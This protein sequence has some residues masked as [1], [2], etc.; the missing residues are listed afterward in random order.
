MK[1]DVARD[2]TAVSYG[3]FTGFQIATLLLSVNQLDI[4]YS[5]NAMYIAA[6]ALTFLLTDRWIYAKIDDQ[7]YRHIFALFLFVSGLLLIFNCLP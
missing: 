6:G 7:K 2:T 5:E 3:I 1:K 4:P